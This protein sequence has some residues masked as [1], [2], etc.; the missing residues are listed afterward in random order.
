MCLLF[1][2]DRLVS[3]TKYVIYIIRSV[4]FRKLIITESTLIIK[5]RISS[6]LIRSE[7]I[8][9]VVNSLNFVNV[10]SHY[11]HQQILLIYLLLHINK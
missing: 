7:S 6:L 8:N 2:E 1:N 10:N 4:I 11:D 3:E 5:Y 9:P